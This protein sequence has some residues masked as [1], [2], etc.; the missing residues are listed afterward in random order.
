MRKKK[1]LLAAILL[2]AAV[3]GLSAG[4]QAELWEVWDVS[5]DGAEADIDHGYWQ[6]F[7]DRYLMSGLPDGISRLD[8]ASAMESG[9][10][11]LERYI[12]DL[13]AVA[14]REYSRDQQFAYWVNLYNAATVRLIVDNY[15]LTSIKKISSPWDQKLLTIEG[16]DVSLNDIEHRIL[17]P[18][19]NDPRI[20]FV[21]NCASLGCPNLHDTALTVENTEEILERSTADYLGHS[22]GVDISSN[23]IVLS[24]IFDWYD[25]DFGGSQKEMLKFIGKYRDIGSLLNSDGSLRSG[26]RLSYEYDWD[27]NDLN[28]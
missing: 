12:A 18:I 28:R 24:S 22:R 7:L 4:A 10:E 8:Y 3:F 23:R 20:H 17:R 25:E 21:V 15:P 13:E 27:L 16:I 5:G 26:L 2:F 1:L 11:L 6:A 14:I 9:R 19:W